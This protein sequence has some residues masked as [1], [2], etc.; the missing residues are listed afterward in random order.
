MIEGRYDSLVDL[1]AGAIMAGAVGYCLF[2]GWTP[3]QWEISAGG[4]LVAFGGTFAA[5][6]KVSPPSALEDGENM[7]SVVPE[8][9][10]FAPEVEGEQ[11]VSAE[12]IEGQGPQIEYANDKILKTADEETADRMI[13]DADLVL[14]D[15][16]AE[17]DPQSRVVRLFAPELHEDDPAA[18]KSRVDRHLAGEETVEENRRL[19]AT[20]PNHMEDDLAAT[21]RL[22]AALDRVRQRLD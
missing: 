17:L 15:I 7:D 11:D 6:R 13:D 5:M 22:A 10:D 2:A 20:K 19:L 16:V 1:A 21:N 3:G 12:D 4:S 14:D 9:L 18:L 8:A